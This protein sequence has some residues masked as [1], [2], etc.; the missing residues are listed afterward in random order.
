M[1]FVLST[2]PSS[3][4]SLAALLQ[5]TPSVHL[6]RDNTKL[7]E[8]VR[9]VRGARELKA[10]KV[11]SAALLRAGEKDAVYGAAGEEAMYQRTHKGQ[12]E[13]S[14]WDLE[15]SLPPAA[16]AMEELCFTGTVQA[17]CFRQ[18][19]WVAEMLRGAAN[20]KVLRLHVYE[21][22]SEELITELRAMDIEGGAVP[23]SSMLNFARPGSRRTLTQRQI[24]VST[25]H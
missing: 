12:S 21:F 7:L 13:R 4:A 8:V 16:P 1:V 5:H 20:L 11:S 17:G 18:M 24:A 23:A 19:E 22:D 9:V 25:S 15:R 6:A 2:L 3:D 10:L 14:L